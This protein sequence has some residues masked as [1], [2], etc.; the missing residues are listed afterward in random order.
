MRMRPKIVFMGTPEFAVA[1]LKACTEL[2]DVVAVVCQPDKPKG[3]GQEVSMPPTKEWALARN[4][5]VIQ[6]VKIRGTSFA[7][8]LAALQPTVAVVTAYG[9]ILPE[10][11]LRVPTFG[12][13]NVH[14]SLLP[15]FRGAAPIQ[16]AVAEGDAET[17]VTLMQMDAGMDT[18]PMLAQ[19]RLAISPSDT[20]AS[21][22]DKLSTLGYE[23]LLKY[24]PDYLEGKLAAT[25]QPAEGV[26]MAP[27]LKKED[28]R[29]NFE[30]SAVELERRVRAF[31]PWPGTFTTLAGHML[32]V[33]AA[34]VGNKQGA[35]GEVVSATPE[36]LEVACR[37][38]SL[39]LT[40]LQPEGKRIMTAAEFLAGRKILPGSRPFGV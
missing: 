13:V 8:D 39:L 5:P 25:L 18:G 40:A 23:V 11:V 38:G 37:E 21:L 28:G 29:L 22:H 34:Q 26:V 19:A 6:P 10:E 9:K 33:K 3:R 35:P 4:L 32:K 30:K 17:G 7:Q 20:G 14:A 15:R 2:G 27:M 24:L 31:T 36:G 12:C 1:S 16:W